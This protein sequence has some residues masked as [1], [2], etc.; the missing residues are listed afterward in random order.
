[1]KDERGRI[2]V[3]PLIGA[4]LLA[5]LLGGLCGLGVGCGWTGGGAQSADAGVQ[6]ATAEARPPAWRRVIE[7]PGTAPAWIPAEPAPRTGLGPYRPDDPSAAFFTGDQA[8]TAW[9]RTPPPATGT[10]RA[11]RPGDDPAFHD[12]P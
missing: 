1:M 11:P 3:P 10:N 7:E 5:M 9:K 12:A 6:G 4:P 8:D 2:L